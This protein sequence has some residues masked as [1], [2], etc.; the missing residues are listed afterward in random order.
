MK[1]TIKDI[2]RELNTTVSTV[3]RALTD[4]PGIGEEMRRKIMAKAREMGYEPNL[5]ARQL[6]QGGSSSI[7]L[8]VPRINRVFFSN[9]IHGVESIARERGYSVI[10][11]QSHEEKSREDENIRT[12]ISNRVAGIIMSLSKETDRADSLMEIMERKIPLVMFDRVF[13][14]LQAGR[15][16]NDNYEAARGITAHLINQG[17]RKIVHYGGPQNINIYRERKAGYLKALEEGGLKAGPG[18]VFKNVITKEGGKERT[19]RLI[20]QGNTFD[21]IFAASDYSALGALLSLKE[22]KIRVPQD[23]GVAGFANEP[24]TELLEI[25]TVEQQSTEIGRSA[26]RLLFEEIDSEREGSGREIVIKPEIIIRNSTLKNR[27]HEI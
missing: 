27:N 11:C 23:V 2:A 18:K 9:V 4:A 21:A 19:D 7:G 24:F 6:R 22:H 12:L 14:G 3:S 15:V 20:K 10:I 16:M 25:T 8:I 5:F 17:Y 26:T 1:V 13:D